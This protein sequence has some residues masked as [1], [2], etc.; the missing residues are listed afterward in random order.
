MSDIITDIVKS[1]FEKL[2]I[3][4]I[5]YVFWLIEIYYFMANSIDYCIVKFMSWFGINGIFCLPQEAINYN[6][7]ILDKIKIWAI[8]IF[9]L[10][11]ILF[12]SGIIISLLKVIPVIGESDIFISYSDYG[13]FI[14]LELILVYGTYWIFQFS[15]LVF[16]F[17]IPV[18]V[19]II[20]LFKKVYNSILDKYS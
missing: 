8:V 4:K 7:I 15:N 18:T 20:K 11:I 14:G 3:Y 6:Q 2:N 16:I 19:I 12:I 17:L 13:L 5:L 10:G 9:Y 1:I